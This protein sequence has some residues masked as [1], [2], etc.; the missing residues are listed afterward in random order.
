M[1]FSK[2]RSIGHIHVARDGSVS[3][4]ADFSVMREKLDP[5]DELIRDLRAALGLAIVYVDHARDTATYE[6]AKRQAGRVWGRCFT[7]L[8]QS[9]DYSEPTEG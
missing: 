4:R 8:A 2:R 9:I 3:G 5:K 7:A 1:M 6:P